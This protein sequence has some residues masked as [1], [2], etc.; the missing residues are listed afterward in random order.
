MIGIDRDTGEFIDERSD[1][2][3][4]P[5]PDPFDID[6]DT[7]YIK[8]ARADLTFSRGRYSAG[9]RGYLGREETVVNG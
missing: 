4:D 5:R 7:E 8:A 6:D 1:T 3:F 9:L 2:R